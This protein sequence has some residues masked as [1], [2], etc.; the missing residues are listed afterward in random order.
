MNPM[1]G[2]RYKEMRKNSG[3]LKEVRFIC[4]VLIRNE[5]CFFFFIFLTKAE[6]TICDNIGELRG[7]YAR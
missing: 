1:K 6:C 7:H 5:E 2:I 3:F 4:G